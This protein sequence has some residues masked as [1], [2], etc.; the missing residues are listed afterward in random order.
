[1]D[2]LDAFQCEVENA[3][4]ALASKLALIFLYGELYGEQ[5]KKR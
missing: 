3:K 5:S 1:M 4:E 2:E